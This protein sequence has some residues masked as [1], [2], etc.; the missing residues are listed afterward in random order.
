MRVNRHER[1][2]VSR[3]FEWLGLEETELV[4]LGIG[5]H[6]P[7]C[8]AASD[9][10]PRGSRVQQAGDL[11]RGVVTGAGCE[12]QIQPV[13]PPF[14]CH[15]RTHHQ[16]RPGTGRGTQPDTPL[17]L[18]RDRPAGH[19]RPESALVCRVSGVQADGRE[20]VAGACLGQHAELVSL[21]VSQHLPW[22][23]ALPDVRSHSAKAQQAVHQPFL[24]GAS[25]PP[26]PKN[27]G[28][29]GPPTHTNL[30]GAP[31]PHNPPPPP[32][33]PP[34]PLNNPPSVQ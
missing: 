2:S 20:P 3:W 25:T 32:P 18:V 22:H 14:G 30:P 17:A 9:V 34:P 21:G 16:G 19:G 24:A 10:H 26:P 8:L 29:G 12:I 5:E 7:W 28:R 13:L 33:P 31:P 11:G 4:S 1:S 15:R 27:G 23:F 6:L